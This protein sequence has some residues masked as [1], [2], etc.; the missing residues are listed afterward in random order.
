MISRPLFA[1]LALALWSGT[2]RADARDDARRHFVTG[3]EAAARGEFEAALT[4][5]LAAQDAYPHPATMANIARAYEDLGQLEEALD[6][7]RRV[8]VAFPERAA[9]AQPHI[10]RLEARLSERAAAA[11][12]PPPPPPPS[13]ALPPAELDRLRAL[14]DELQAALAALQAAPSE[15]G[16]VESPPAAEPA[17]PDEPA[18]APAALATAPADPFETEAYGRIVVTASRY[19][20]DPLDSPST[21]SVITAD[22]IRLSGATNVPDLL[23]RVAGVDVMSLSS[24]NP[25]V[26]IRGFNS[27]LSNKVLWLVDGRTVYWDFLAAPLALNLSFGLDEIERIEVIR[28]PGSASYGANAMTGVINIITRAPGQG[29][30]LRVSASGGAPGF[31]NA[32]AATSGTAGRFGWRFGAGYEQEGRWA[33]EDRPLEDGPTSPWTT[34]QDLA[35]RKLRADGRIDT[36]FGKSG[37]ASLSGGY[38]DGFLEFYNIGALGNYGV[39]GQTHHLRGDVAWDPVRLVTYWNHEDVRTG[40]WFDDL[41]E[42]RALDAQVRNDV[43]QVEVEATPSFTTGEVHHQLGLGAGY[44]YKSTAFDY[45][46]G[47]YD[48]PWIEHHLWAFAQEQLRWRWLGVVASLRVDRHPLLP[49]SKTLSPRGALLFRVTPDT[50]L[51]LSGG[52]AYRAMAAVESYMDFALDTPAA[53]YFI[54]DYGGETAPGSPGL[55]P[56]RIVT[57]ELGAHD[58]SSAWHALDVTAYWN[59]VTNLIGLDDVTPALA[60]YDASAN[61]FLAGTTGWINGDD[62]YDAF[63]GE[64]ELEVFPVDGLDAFANV[65]IERI[66]ERGVEG[67]VIDGSTSLARVN[68]GASYRAPFRMDFSFTGHYLSPQAW[69]LREFDGD[70]RLVTSVS[71]VNGRFLMSARIAGRPLPTPNLE[72]ALT[73][74]NPTGFFTPYQEHPKGQP[75]GGRLFATLSLAL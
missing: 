56:E 54:R 64:A 61:G 24:A 37:F 38:T 73:L 35:S 75:V 49:V 30:K 53:G 31:L 13:G 26:G 21:I 72:L 68:F 36:S 3:L 17:A 65:S 39:E 20:Q 7:H 70:G 74:W 8:T 29:P 71:D 18:Q 15:P 45:L 42:R 34:N 62:L 48:Q 25:S 27:E 22:D 50:S 43:V 9:D 1:A 57:V 10:A 19:G 40:P 14:A 66:F 63:G 33:K 23:R 41:D 47:G 58:Q 51:R 67:T 52:T 55:N 11:A 6:W 60:P 44:R 59:R 4:S 2:A 5:F 69:R 32:S 16:A 12:P 46:Q 28:G